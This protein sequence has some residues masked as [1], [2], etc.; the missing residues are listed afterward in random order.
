[1]LFKGCAQLCAVVRSRALLCAVVR[2]CAQLCAVVRSCALLCAGFSVTARWRC[3]M[4][5]L[6]VSRA[7]SRKVSLN[8]M[9]L[10][11]LT[12]FGTLSVSLW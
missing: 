6:F 11:D 5:P 7:I 9:C 12:S 2:S 3:P 10:R 4:K 8:S 1:M